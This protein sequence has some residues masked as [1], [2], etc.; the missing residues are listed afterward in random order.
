MGPARS[1]PAPASTRRPPAPRPAPPVASASCSG[2]GLREGWFCERVAGGQSDAD[3]FLTE[4][5][6][7]GLLLGRDP[8]LPAALV[9]WTATLFPDETVN[10][11]RAREAACWLAD[12]G[13]HDHPEYRAEQSFNRIL[14][15]PGG[16]LDHPTRA[17]LA[18]AV[19]I[20]YEAERDVAF[21]G[22]A[23][24]LLDEPTLARAEQLGLALR[25]ATM[26]SAGTPD[27]LAGAGL[28]RGERRLALTLRRG[29][30]LI[31]GDGTSI[32]MST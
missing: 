27:L 11:R 14:R 29:V 26:L 6:D 30:G 21:L 2:H 24:T 25:L 32:Q 9:A 10:D 1:A 8:G 28:H 7:I 5:R 18:A 13:S 16:A 31:G 15:Q 19:A 4:Q 3:P 23:R 17:F 12:T 20:R 22:I